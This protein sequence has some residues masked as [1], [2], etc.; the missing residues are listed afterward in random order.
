MSE[1][2]PVPGFDGYFAGDDGTIYSTRRSHEMRPLKPV[3]GG[4]ANGDYLYVCLGRGNR[5]GVHQVVA[6]TFLDRPVVGNGSKLLVRHRDNNPH[7]NSVAN[8]RWGTQKQNLDDR[9]EHGTLT[10]GTRNGA[11]K[12][13]EVAVSEIRRRRSVGE[14]CHA[15]ARDYGVSRAH[16]HRIGLGARWNHVNTPPAPRQR[17]RRKEPSC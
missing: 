9:A 12:L 6:M 7:N 16:I 13:S 5:R 11:A 14:Q 4:G 3:P 17:R 2:R 15:I 10:R 8:L 1:V